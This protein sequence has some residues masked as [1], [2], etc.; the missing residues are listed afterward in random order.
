V[1]R[2]CAAAFF[3]LAACAGPRVEGPER[4]IA[5][6]TDKP[7]RAYEVLG[8]VRAQGVPGEHVRLVYDRLRDNARRLGADAVIAVETQ[9]YFDAIPVPYDPPP[10]PPIGAAYPG[11]LHTFEPGAFP[12]EGFGV[13]SRGAYYAAEGL[14][15]RFHYRPDS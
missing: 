7:Q 14:A 11:P 1:R 2:L 15:I 9:E 12:P 4:A 5:L 8:P 3:A 13:H 6:F 10:R